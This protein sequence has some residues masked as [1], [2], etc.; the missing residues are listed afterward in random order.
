MSELKRILLTGG[1]TAG[2]VN[3]ALAIGRALSGEGTRFLYVGVRGRAEAEVVPREGMP[4]RF[5]RASGYPGGRPSL[6]L[7]RFLANLGVGVVQ[8]VVILL[9]FRP[10]V[11]VGTGG[12]ASAPIMFASAI[13][14]RLGLLR[15]GVFVH[16][17]NAAPGKLNQ[18]VGRV[19][20]RV[21][22][23][24]PE[25]FSS[26]PSNGVVTGYPLRGR[27]AVVDRTEAGRRL[28][29]TLPPGRRVIFVFGGSQGARTINRA[30]VDALGDLLP[31]RD[32]LFIIHGT[33][34][35]RGRD[36]HATDD[37][38]ARIDA[39]YTE[40]ERRQI[41]TFYVS[42]PFFYQIEN[43]YA[44]AD[45]VVARAG[46]GSLYELASLGLPAI[47]IPKANLPG[48]H[49]VM[50]ARAM[51]RCGGALV[52]YE[53]AALVNGAI[54][55]QV[56]GRQLATAIR[57]L[58]DDTA[59]LAEMGQKSRT[60]LRQ[61]A[62]SLIVRCIRGEDVAGPTGVDGA[63]FESLPTNQA[64]L[65]RLERAAAEK[66]AAYSPDFVVPSPDDRAY[67]V[68]RAASLLVSADWERRNLGVKLIG[69]LHAREK[70]PLLLALLGDRRPAALLKRLCGG[71]YEQV[72]FIRRNILAAIARLG[73]TTPEVEAALVGAFADPYFEARAEAARTAAALG[74]YLQSR[75]QI[76]QGL[77]RLLSDRWL[78]VAAAAA[79]ALGRVG[80]ET[81]ALPALLALKGARFWRVRAAALDGLVTLVERGRAGD[82]TRLMPALQEFVLT[83]TDFKPEFQIKRL[84]GRLLQ[85]I[86]AREGG[87]R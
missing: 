77:E 42:R 39:Q 34:L 29:F 66:G 45:L 60:F 12:F 32:R 65:S 38:Q 33:G 71:D 57:T 21:F 52:I 87:A 63:A 48:D 43:I 10:D 81:D 35:F 36:Y 85:A 7:V 86:A 55:E 30:I 62:L 68:S 53:E 37:T 69:L 27:I 51:A 25:T 19:A 13:L 44:V 72:G 47:V 6:E 28:D 54:V 59:R 11:I 8:A 18:L 20:D 84:Y 58:I 78:E 41:A 16:E 24:F 22:V 31:L 3:P 75:Q 15:A 5:V 49:Q 9:S 2:H 83:S 1:G 82:L 46:A 50:N 56:D 76:V 80:D 17:Q 26:F 40:D 74:A 79:Q 67:F 64:L 70:L 4:I 73:V 61:D 23:T 14:R